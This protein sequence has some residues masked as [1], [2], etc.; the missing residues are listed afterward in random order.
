M[1]AIDRREQY[2]WKKLKDRAKAWSKVYRTQNALVSRSGLLDKPGPD[3]ASFLTN[4]IVRSHTYC[5]HTP[6]MALLNHGN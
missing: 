3:L 2:L 5:K 1:R 4:S 6:R